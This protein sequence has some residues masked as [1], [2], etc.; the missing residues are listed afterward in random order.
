VRNLS[1]RQLAQTATLY[2]AELDVKVRKLIQKDY[3]H[4]LE[5]MV[6]DK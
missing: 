2:E 3:P 1:V 5:I 4:L 6:A